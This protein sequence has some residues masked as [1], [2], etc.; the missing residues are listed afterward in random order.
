[1]SEIKPGNKCVV[2]EISYNYTH[3]QAGD[4]S[5]VGGRGVCA[6][7][8]SMVKSIGESSND[9]KRELELHCIK[10]VHAEVWV[11][12]SVRVSCSEKVY[13]LGEKN[14][15]KKLRKRINC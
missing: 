13:E 6:T 1:M 2:D 8:D 12:T 3:T 9:C 5:G 14:L 4:I 15:R 10:D 7:F 11:L